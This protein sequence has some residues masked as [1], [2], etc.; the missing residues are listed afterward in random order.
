MD[1]IQRVKLRYVKLNQALAQNEK[2]E[3]E[4]TRMRLDKEATERI[5]KNALGSQL[6][7]D[8]MKQKKANST[9]RNMMS[10]SEE[11]DDNA[12]ED[13]DEQAD[14]MKKKGTKSKEKA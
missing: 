7:E 13:D 8:Q 12:K 5:V 1:Q 9:K 2:S 4:S 3:K 6:K 11:S 14:D 10:D